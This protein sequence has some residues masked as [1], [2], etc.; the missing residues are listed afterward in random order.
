MGLE[1][2]THGLNLKLPLQAPVL[3]VCFQCLNGGTILG[4]LGN[5]LVVG[6]GSQQ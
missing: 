6:P 4:K 1:A 5:L 2:S 3:N